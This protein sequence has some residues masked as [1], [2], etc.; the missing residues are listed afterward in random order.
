MKKSFTILSVL[1]L[2]F[3]AA[4][5]KK[6]TNITTTQLELLAKD[7]KIVPIR[8]MGDDAIMSF[9]GYAA[10]TDITTKL[11]VKT[12]A[13]TAWKDIVVNNQNSI[14]VDSLLFET[15]YVFRV[16]LSRG[17]ETKYSAFDTITT[18]N[19][20]INYTR[21]FNG[22]SNI[23]DNQNGI[24]SIEGARHIIYGGGFENEQSIKVTFSPIDNSANTFSTTATIIN[25]SM[26]SFEI[27]RNTIL[28]NP[29]ST[30]SVYS[31]MINDLPLIGYKA[32]LEDDVLNKAD[33]RIVNKD[34][35]IN[36]FLADGF[37]CKVINLYGYFGIHETETVTPEILY[38]VSMRIKE[39]KLIVTDVAG[40]E[41][42]AYPLTPFGSTI[43]NTDGITIADFVALSQSMMAYHEVTNITVKSSLPS[44]T[45]KAYVREVSKDDVV[46]VSNEVSLV[47]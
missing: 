41:V 17:A 15:S 33:M 22:P 14:A 10:Q 12:L 47:F 2:S 4:C 37:G 35:R 39:R 16:A 34:L 40:T 5:K 25:D 7:I 20:A 27:P 1:S 21:Y 18:R 29:Y 44:G 38:N 43:C 28:N 6:D 11:Q 32:F 42:A 8:V 31:C 24:F 45:Y 46:T 3:F 26:I 19:F 9:I 13:A 23:H 30:H 36:S